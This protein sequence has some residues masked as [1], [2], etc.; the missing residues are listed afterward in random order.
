MTALTEQES[1]WVDDLA[2]RLRLIQA[3]A[4]AAGAEKR[5]DYLQEEVAREFAEVPPGNRQR[6][7]TAL[8]ARFPVCG[9]TPAAGAP[10]PAPPPPP[11]A[12]ETAEQILERF[13]AAAAGVSEERRREMARRLAD[14]GLAW[15][16][17]DAAVLDLSEELRRKLG[18]PAGQQVRATRM[19]ELAMQLI[20]TLSKLDQRSLATLRDLSARSPL[21][22]RAQPFRASAAQ[23]L[24]SEGESLEPHLRGITALLG[25]LLAAILAGGKEFGRQHWEQFSPAVIEGV[26]AMEGSK[27]FGPSAKERCWDKYAELAGLYAAPEVMD[28]QIKDC[29]AR[30][31]DRIFASQ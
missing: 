22:Q 4:A 29:L 17:R 18:V 27:F 6:Y 11:P 19:A 12:A 25:A 30:F 2:A 10:A 26:V 28:K 3:G 7:L 20:D 9:R 5:R 1:E 31:V 14:K 13:L 23:F 16:D 24:T 15:Y 8:V 21:L